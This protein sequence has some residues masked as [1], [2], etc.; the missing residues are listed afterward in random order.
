MT[1]EVDPLRQE[2]ADSWPHKMDDSAARAEWGWQP[3][4]DIESMTS[5]MIEKLREKLGTLRALT[6]LQ[7]V[8]NVT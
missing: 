6:P 5:D 2:I 7:E 3:E 1:N 8:S 4:Y